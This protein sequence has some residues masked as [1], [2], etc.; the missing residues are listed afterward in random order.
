MMMIKMNIMIKT[1]MMRIKILIKMIDDDDD[2][3]DE[4]NDQDG[5]DDHDDDQGEV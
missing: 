5:H 4:D 1:I 3:D 2:E